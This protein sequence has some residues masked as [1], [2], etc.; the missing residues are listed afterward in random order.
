M[1]SKQYRVAVVGGAGTWG[2]HYLDAYARHRECEIVALVDLAKDRRQAIAGQYGIP[3]VYDT[4]D[5]LLAKDVPD[6]VTIALPVAHSPSAV[7]TCAKAGVKSISCEKPIAVSLE[8]ADHM[9]RVCREQGA[10]LACGT[11]YWDAPHAIEVADWIQ[12]GHIGRLTSASISQGLS[13][14]V[15]GSGCVDFVLLHALT[16]MEVQWV[17]GW[18][19]PPQEDYRTPQAQGDLETDCNAYGQLGLGD[20][21]V[22]HIPEPPV[23]IVGH[24]IFLNICGEDGQV[25][26]TSHRPILIQGKGAKAMPVFPNF[27]NRHEPD[28]W[29]CVI[30][31]LIK[32]YD[33]GT[34]PLCNGDCYRN[35]LEVAIALKLSDANHHQ[36]VD[37]P[38]QDRSGKIYPRSLRLVGKDA[39]G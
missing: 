35:A 17:E 30:N 31:D 15:S 37:L 29:T 23:D 2:L 8:E 11:G 14:E 18:C 13:P 24:I 4:V 25:W 12:A 5:D 32:T 21:V 7:V 26:F 28:R 3:V 38:L 22:C 36:R 9:V 16:G 27:L 1:R 10:A 39:L 33:R 19:L 6:I 20:D 34:E